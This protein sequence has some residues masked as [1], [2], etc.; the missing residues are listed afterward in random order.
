MDNILYQIENKLYLNI[1][2]QCPCACTFCIRTHKDKMGNSSVL[3]LEQEPTCELIVEQLEKHNLEEYEELVF[4]G[5]GEPLVRVDI[6]CEIARYMRGKT[7]TPIK[8]NTNGLCNLYHKRDIT[9]EFQGLIDI[10]SISLNASNPQ[11]YLEITRS[12]F[13]IESFEQMLDFAKKSQQY[14]KEVVLSV[15]DVIGEE[16]IEKCRKICE[17]IQVTYR[18][19]EF[20][21]K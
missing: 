3:W 11:D 21:T 2:N 20:E 1:T 5:F 18:V 14:V 17:E 6:V 9:P 15:V 12:Q 8:I 4:C 19:R 10:I 7:K 13:G 16:E